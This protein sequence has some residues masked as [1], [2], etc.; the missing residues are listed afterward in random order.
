MNWYSKSKVFHFYHGT[1][2][3]NLTGIKGG[4][5]NPFLCDSVEKANYYAEEAVGVSGG[6]EGYL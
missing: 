5:K 3:S 6:V 2:S 4:L 1:S